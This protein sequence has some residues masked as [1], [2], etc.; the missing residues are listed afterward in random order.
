MT[1]KEAASILDQCVRNELRDHAFG[2]MEI[3]WNDPTTGQEIASGYSG[4]GSQYV[5][6]G[7]NS[8]NGYEDV[9]ELL[10]HGCSHNVERNDETG[11]DEFVRGRTMPSL[12]KEAI[13][14]E[15][16]GD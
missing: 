3:S 10:T 14:R 13:L 16:L 1:L 7:E 8:F 5:T 11:P 6:I 2:D 9:E 15:L 4:N 12:T